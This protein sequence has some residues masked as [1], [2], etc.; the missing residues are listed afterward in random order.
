MHCI[1]ASAAIQM[2]RFE[3]Q[4]FDSSAAITDEQRTRSRIGLTRLNNRQA[5]ASAELPLLQLG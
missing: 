5:A 2:P 3:I 4:S 1:D